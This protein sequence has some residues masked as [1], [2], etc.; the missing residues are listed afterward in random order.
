MAA[1]AP[2]VSLGKLKHDIPTASPKQGHVRGWGELES[3]AHI[4]GALDSN[5]SEV[6]KTRLPEQG[7]KVLWSESTWALRAAGVCR[8]RKCTL[9][10]VWVS[11]VCLIFFRV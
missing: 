7:A 3:A 4:S 10:H 9:S 11:V 6:W 2:S 5:P 8:V 1:Q